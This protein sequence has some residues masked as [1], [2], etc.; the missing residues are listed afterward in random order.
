MALID[1][2]LND[3]IEGGLSAVGKPIGKA[4]DI[5]KA[6]YRWA[7]RFLSSIVPDQIENPIV[8]TGKAVENYVL[9]PAIRSATAVSFDAANIFEYLLADNYESLFQRKKY[10]ERVKR[11][12]ALGYVTNLKDQLI[13]GQGTNDLGTGYLPGGEAF[14]RSQEQIL[15]D[16]P[17]VGE[18]PYTLGR[19]GAYPGVV[20]NLYNQDSVLYKAISGGIDAVKVVKNPIDPANWIT[21]I[22]P[23]GTGAG[24]RA[25]TARTRVA[26]KDDFAQYFDKLEDEVLTVAEDVA[27]SGRQLTPLE[28]TRASE[29][30]T[31]TSRTVPTITR[32]VPNPLLPGTT[33]TV[34]GFEPGNV[35]D[36]WRPDLDAALA[37]KM[38]QMG[39]VRDVAPSMIRNNYT[40]WRNSGR[41]SEWA[42][43]LL[44]GIQ[45][46]ELNA[47]TIWRTVLNREGPQTAALLVQE[48]SR[49]GATIDD[50]WRVVD[51]AV[52]SFEP[53]F[54]LRNI[55]R[56]SFDAFRSGDGN[57]IRYQ[58]Q[59]L[60]TRQF[61]I[62]PESTRIG[63]TDVHQSAKNLDN[64]MGS[65]GFDL[66][67][68]DEWLSKFFVASSGS[69]DDLFKF[70]GD[71][72]YQAIGNRLREIALPGSTRQLL[73][74]DVIRE[75]TSWTQK[76]ADE[77]RIYAMDDVG[78]AV[79]L[80]WLDADQIGPLRLTQQ[81]G[82][83][84]FL[85]PPG[86]VN[87]MV[88]LTG[89]VGAFL[90][91]GEQVPVVGRGV[92]AYDDAVRGI[93]SYMSNYWKPAR[94]A[95]PSHLIRVV[96]E[97]VLKSM[98][99]GVFEH[100][101]EQILAMLSLAITRDA[102]GNI[103]KGKI[104]NIIKMQTKLDGLENDLLEALQY[105][106]Q[107]AQGIQI[108]AK[109]QKFVNTIPD[110]QKNISDLSAKINANPQAIQ[111]VLIGPRSR[112][113]MASA[114]G[115]YAPIYINMQRR[116][117]MQLPDR[118]ISNQRSGW[119][120]GV[121]QEI[122]DMA[123]NED[124]RRIAG[125]RLFPDDTITIN[126]A[127]KSIDGHIT[128]GTIHP[129]TGAPIAN[130]MDAVKLW[131]FQGS[132][133]QYFDRYFDNMANLQPQYRGGGYDNYATASERVDI[134]YSN[135]IAWVTGFDQT[136][137][138]L[139]STGEY[140][141]V[142]AV[143]RETTGRGKVSPELQQ[144]LATDFINRPHAP[145]KVKFFPERMLSDSDF[146]P[147][148]G[149]NLLSGLQRLYGFYFEQ[150]YGR[151]SDFAARSPTWKANYWNRMEELVPLMTPADAQATVAAAKKARLTATRV[152]RIELQAALANGTGELPGAQLLAEQYASRATNDLIF[153][154][155]KRSLFGQQ[156][157]ILM[158]FFEAFRE[159]TFSWMKLTAMNPR[160][161]R[162]TAQFVDSTQS[163]GVTTTNAD[164]RKVF[165]IPMTGKLASMMIGSDK[166]VIKNFTVG[167][168][169]VN[170]AL[171]LRPG[172]GPVIQYAVDDMAPAT[173]D[174]DWLR[175]IA[176]PY[177]FTS[178]LETFVPVPVQL[179]Q[180]FQLLGETPG[181]KDVS[182]IT[183]VANWLTSYEGNDYKQKATIY[184]HQWLVN[185]YP[186]K[187]EGVDG[188]SEAFDD[189]EEVA[190]K[191]TALRGL[192]AVFGPGAP[193]TTWVS[194]TKYGD[195]D[196]AI[197]L[198]DLR[199]L[200][201]QYRNAGKTSSEAYAKW[202]DTW[203][204][205]VWPLVGA[206]TKNNIGGQVASNEF[207]RWVAENK[208]LVS[209]YPLVAGYLGPRSGERT[210]E[211]WAQ[212]S[213]AGRREIQDPEEAV[214]QAQ[215]RL[216]NYLY[217]SK[218]DQFSPDQLKTVAVR[219]FLANELDNIEKK[220]PLF[221]PP[222]EARL[223]FQQRNR[224]Q[225]AQLRAVGN[226][227]DLQSNQVVRDLSTYFKLLDESI[228]NT[229]RMNPTVNIN[230]WGQVKAAKGLRLHIDQNIA[231]PL[232]A[233]NPAF[234]DVY[235][236]VLSYEFIL[237]ED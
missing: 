91:A 47:G 207:N 60:G 209:Q 65:F 200:E 164:G 5:G 1:D 157:R 77:V 34:R 124:Y 20:L 99:S 16:R 197:V 119:T 185:N 226:N 111:D 205:A 40:A 107:A 64:L 117:I 174:Y 100:P 83:D 43:D 26:T 148:K 76:L 224:Q 80:P 101:G 172:F 58:A 88:R 176:S 233:N 235:E 52:A 128:D 106:K 110:L 104:P 154:V 127:T 72:E 35:Y 39:A 55:S 12:G 93:Q 92:K 120:K 62:L 44:S 29:Y 168:N 186:E 230:N 150:M 203:G 4:F 190:N 85:M 19:A 86:A 14:R 155:N 113:A 225:I 153:N 217:Y 49:P 74:D 22:K 175:N 89:T 33:K 156:H 187:Y 36:A 228:Q 163:E 144:W 70:L 216:G 212:Q 3:K 32:D 146:A 13:F 129:Y 51:E 21:P 109:Q 8:S 50:V 219:Q 23:G 227:R 48:L 158:P 202:L 136:L 63:L 82:D 103:I 208:K 171:Q 66:A 196:R 38:N 180:V 193:I 170:I 125:E 141:G 145:Q 131:L 79:P 112:G 87:E 181:V 237:D 147:R 232:I 67:Q 211:A 17:K 96:P 169:A 189:A 2:E 191:I 115:E 173:P 166:T 28:I 123:Y 206:I 192:T 149:A 6:G 114:T 45:S 24:S 165:E 223:D 27:I 105:Q 25:A 229:I 195:V 198:D 218:R 56:S 94:V 71:F 121:T 231:A 116:G 41:G 134:I 161:I 90:R 236:Q 177:G 137:L 95:K 139:I 142:R 53:G 199:N 138:D 9:K 215:Q 10:L 178:F 81:I 98:A 61:E 201:D 97:E 133:R 69:K 42:Q 59:K 84:Y 162:N 78:N 37:N 11:E 122:V 18:L 126:G 73:P 179:G 30:N 46:G 152:E 135:D 15:A 221:A 183:E 184:S 234:R 160:I 118:T 210:F 132:G 220:L 31:L 182:A 140:N 130:D 54:N 75:L 151:V 222:G 57:V 7:D 68:R 159:V 167:T 213:A 194:K 214:R 102:A 204:E 108:T 188:L 143:F